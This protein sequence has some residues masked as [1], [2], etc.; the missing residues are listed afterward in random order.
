MVKKLVIVESPAK[1][2]TIKK[3]LGRNYEVTASYGHIRDL[4]K[5]KLGVDIENGFEPSY[6][7][8]KGKG[9]VIKKI[10]ELAKKADKI[11]IASDMDREGEAIAWHIYTAL[12]LKDENVRIEFNEI[13]ETAIKNAVKNPRKIDINRFDAQQARRILDR[14]VGYKISP[15][16][17][18]II[19]GNTSAGRVQSVA[20]KLI[21]D[22]EDI[23]VKFIPEKYWEISGD[24]QNKL[25]LDL[26]KIADEKGNRVKNEELVKEIK[27]KIKNKEFTIIK[28][29]ISQKSQ[30][31]P[32]ALKTS[33]LQQ[34]ASSSLGFSASRTMRTAQGLYEGID[35]GGDHVGLITY[36][37][38]DSTRI[39][40]DA[41]KA[42]KEY[43][44]ET[45]GE[46]YIGDYVGGK[47]KGK[48]QDAHEAIRPTDITI[49]PDSIKSHLKEEQY[50]LYK[51]IWT[52]FLV[53]QLSNMEYNHFE[54]VAEYDKYQFRGT[55]K[56]ITFDGYYKVFKE[57][58]VEEAEF[59]EIK[60]N[61]KILLE[62]LNIKAGETTPPARLNEASLVKK[63]ESEGIGRPSTYASIIETLKKREYVEVEKKVF[64]PT[65][66]GYEV[67]KHLEENFP[68]IMN[69]KFTAQMEENLDSIEEGDI[70]WKKVLGDFYEDL[71]KY[72]VEFEKKVEEIK[73]KKV[74]T[75]VKCKKCNAEMLLKRGRFGMYLECENFDEE[76]HDERISLK[77]V[78]ISFAELEK[79][80]V[81]LADIVKEVEKER[82]AKA[83]DV[84]CSVCGGKMFVKKGRYGFYLECEKYEECK[85]RQSIP[86]SA[87]LTE[88]ED[89]IIKLKS[90]LDVIKAEEDKIINAAGKCEKCGSTFIIK[91]GRFGPFLA[92][93]GY[94]DCKNI[95]KI[96][97]EK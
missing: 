66:L 72:L 9:D 51:L 38:T 3:I 80:V 47:T 8:I 83:S 92:C 16:L 78:D 30:K 23:I 48:V 86:R 37:R 53:S 42:A 91:K 76:T 14:L 20:L 70:D 93:S 24:F 39:S 27:V 33:T 62:K 35:I 46:K 67:K 87:D 73:N 4:P 75:D 69:V 81:E 25:K 88:D 5:T 74:F 95:K 22:L 59:P 49:T 19:N 7:T 52:R 26:Y 55:A 65:D 28:T 29:K 34:L 68:N 10:K 2:S 54:M 17:W 71:E 58:E 56:N 6:T 40:E 31:A 57:E 64:Y 61:D 13:T 18:K 96:P 89:G 32:I 82:E 12:K 94:P 97:K 11:Y 85:G 77:G 50:K 15:L 41:K 84:E 44:T 1:A 90:I 36:M 43:I 63:L 79:E 21:C 45:F 60:E